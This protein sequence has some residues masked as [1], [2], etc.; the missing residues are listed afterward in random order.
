MKRK[1]LAT[2][3]L[4]DDSTLLILEKEPPDS[5]WAPLVHL[6]SIFAVQPS[7]DMVDASQPLHRITSQPHEK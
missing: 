4:E 7:V 1:Q 6:V 5:L 2:K 3:V